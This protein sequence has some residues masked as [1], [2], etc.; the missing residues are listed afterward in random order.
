VAAAG[1][2]DGDGIDDVLVAAA[3]WSGVFLGPVAGSLGEPDADA[4]FDGIGL[5]S[6]LTVGTGDVDGDGHPDVFVGA[7][8]ADVGD[9][10]AAGQA[11][12]FAGPARGAVD[13]ADAVAHVVG[14]HASLN[15]GYELTSLRSASGSA[16]DLIVSAS[17]YDCVIAPG[18]GCTTGDAAVY[19]FAAPV[20]GELD[21]TC[22]TTTWESAEGDLFGHT[23]EAHVD[24]DGSGLPD[25]LVSAGNTV[26]LF[27]DP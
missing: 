14:E 23:I 20:T 27:L 6:D 22:A 24:A 26:I 1:D 7:P 21:A 11:W 25:L 18:P 13:F 19:R 9:M 17:A 10:D 8:Y 5:R 12:V 4:A 15:L 16:S 3:G 2:H